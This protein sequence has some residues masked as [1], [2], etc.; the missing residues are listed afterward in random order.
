MAVIKI[1]RM[2]YW[3]NVL[4]NTFPP[5]FYLRRYIY[6]SRGRIETHPRSFNIPYFF[7]HLCRVKKTSN[8]S[9]LQQNGRA[10]RLKKNIVKFYD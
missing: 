3:C 7:F 4:F 8:L 6:V 9:Y 2:R 10:A 5:F 1:I